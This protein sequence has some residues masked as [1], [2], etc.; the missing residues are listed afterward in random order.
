MVNLKLCIVSFSDIRGG[1]AKAALRIRSA[2]NDSGVPSHYV[3]A[4]KIDRISDSIGPSKL[5]FY[6]HFFLRLISYF[7]LKMMRTKNPAKHSLNIFSSCHVLKEI[8]PYALLHIHWINNDTISIRKLSDV[9]QAHRVVITLH[10]EWF[11][12]G[13]EHHALGEESYRRVVRGYSK[14]NKNVNGL[15]LN[16]LI[17]QKKKKYYPHLNDVIF[18]VPSTWMKVRAENSFLLRDKDIRVLPNPIDTTVF[19]KYI[20]NNTIEGINKDDFVITFGAVGGGNSK[21]KGFDLLV[22]AI[23]KFAGTFSDLSK[24]KIIT[25]GGKEKKYSSM[26]GFDVIELGHISNESELAKI[27]SLTSVTVVPSRAESFGQVAAESL[28]CETPVLSFNCTG[29]TDIIKHKENGFLAEPFSPSSLSDG[30]LWVYKLN[31]DDR[32]K[33][34]ES[35]RNH[36]VKN[37]STDVVSE[38]LINIY[39]ELGYEK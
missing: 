23:S 38:Q 14:K 9:C 26:F 30:L 20:G 27:F 3:V 36:I 25:F 17:W 5:S 32:S 37:F 21:V 13:A 29:L 24:V 11:Y 15:D 18:T 1:A 7:L 16:K 39:K 2:I 31:A 22:L 8:E 12:C 4:E 33:L 6:Y 28:S 19:K 34:G 10:D 35:G